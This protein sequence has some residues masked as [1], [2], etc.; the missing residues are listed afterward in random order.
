[1][2]NKKEYFLIN[3]R[4]SNLRIIMKKIK[5]R[6]CYTSERILFFIRERICFS[7]EELEQLKDEVETVNVNADKFEKVEEH[8][9]RF[10]HNSEEIT[11]RK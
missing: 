5:Y 2:N 7:K 10:L 9:R 3:K 6:F 1:M 8:Y 11:V 4:E